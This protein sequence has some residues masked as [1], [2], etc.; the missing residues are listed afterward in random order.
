MR[1]DSGRRLDPAPQ[2]AAPAE[3]G[4]GSEEVSG[5][6]A[7]AVRGDEGG[8]TREFAEELS[9]SRLAFPVVNLLMLG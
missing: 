1:L 8:K 2:L 6:G 4:S 9:I 5:L 7:G 3:G